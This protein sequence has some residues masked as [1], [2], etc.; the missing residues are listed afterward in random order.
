MILIVEK[1]SH[2][3]I[4]VAPTLYACIGLMNTSISSFELRSMLT[5]LLILHEKSPKQATQGEA[6]VNGKQIIVTFNP[7]ID[8]KLFHDYTQKIT[9]K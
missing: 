6:W 4:Q 2:T 3:Y 9:T 7:N 1:D 5:Q 8:N